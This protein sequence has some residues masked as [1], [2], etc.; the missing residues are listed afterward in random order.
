[1]LFPAILVLSL[2]VGLL[3][4]VG[5]PAVAQDV[6]FN[7][8]SGD[9]RVETAAEISRAH[10]EPG[11]DV[12]FVTRHDAFPDAL[13]GGPVAAL[14]GAPILLTRTSSLPPATAQE[15]RR[16]RPRR[17]VVLGGESVVSGEVAALLGGLAPDGVRRQAG[18]DRFATAAAVATAGFGPG[19]PVAYV[20]TGL[21]F[22]DALAGG[23]AAAREG[24]PILLVSSTDVPSP[25]LDALRTLRPERV[26][27]LGGEAAIPG[28]VRERIAAVTG[29]QVERVWGP[30]RVATA[31]A[32]SRRA[33]PGGA[34]EVFVATGL[35][36]PDSLAAVPPAHLRDAPLLLVTQ[37]VTAALRA[38]IV[39]LAPSRINVLGGENAVA[40]DVVRELERLL[41]GEQAPP[42]GDPAPAPGPAPTATPTSTSGDPSGAID[43]WYGSRQTVGN[44]GR[45]Q[46]RAN[47]VGS[48][49]PDVDGLSYRLNGGAPVQLRLG[50]DTRRLCS[51]GEFNIEI[52]YGSLR[53]GDNQVEIRATSGTGGVIGRRTVT[54]RHDS[55][56]AMGLPGTYTVDWG[57]VA[58]ID[59]VAHV[60]DGL[61]RLDG[62][63]VRS[64]Q[65]AYD[66]M[67]A[68]G[69]TSWTDYEVT[70]PITV[71]ERQDVSGHPSYNDAVGLVLR[72]SDHVEWDG[73]TEPRWGFYP[74]GAL[75]VYNF[76]RERLEIQ[77]NSNRGRI[78]R[79]VVTAPFTWQLGVPYVMKARVQTH[80]Q[81][82]SHY[83]LK[84]WRQGQAE[85]SG[86][87]VTL[88]QP[89]VDD[90][91]AGS[92]V[93]LAHHVRA[94]FGQVTVRRL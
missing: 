91:P 55:T 44:H 72:W 74:L 28:A 65:M 66:R 93:L 10:F 33:F 16:L 22:P 46:A 7:R 92:I 6:S 14:A 23:V 39:R 26:V 11:V 81:G 31:A 3:P 75:P 30:D 63:A 54:V 59:E 32:I 35:D 73:I 60:T 19:V 77:G 48:V 90:H 67:I 71:H 62:G 8:V 21:D 94:S 27:L 58:R 43:V 18:G 88:E 84:A 5:G 51:R 70:V 61:W 20:A 56:P 86:W 42:G 15:L 38:E 45:P 82:G 29:A 64:T 68:L 9:T 80:P 17:I 50:P 1:M 47:V 78:A 79:Q 25:T 40:A 13:A 49:A 89:E 24:G 12:A 37:R 69:D 41:A 83:R 2:V 34:G 57:D 4:Q 76:G 36:F 87:H 53:T 85:P 52:P